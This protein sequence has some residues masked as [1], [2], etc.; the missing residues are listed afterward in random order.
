MKSRKIWNS[1]KTDWLKS[2][3]AKNA[4][5]QREEQFNPGKAIDDKKQISF[6]DTDARIMGKNC[7]FNYASMPK[8]AS[9]QI[10][11]LKLLWLSIS[12]KTPTINKKLNPYCKYWKIPA[13]DCPRNWVSI[14]A[15]GLETI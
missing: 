9:M 13:A 4:L 15:I 3:A 6:A 12:T 1:N 2:K 8:L 14:T 7:G 5:E 11:K 10:Y